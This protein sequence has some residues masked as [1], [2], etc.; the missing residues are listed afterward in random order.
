VSRRPASCRSRASLAA[1]VD[2]VRHVATGDFP[3]AAN[4]LLVLLANLCSVLQSHQN[5]PVIG[6]RCSGLSLCPA[7]RKHP[8]VPNPWRTSSPLRPGLGFPVHTAS[9]VEGDPR[10][11]H[12]E[13]YSVSPRVDLDIEFADVNVKR[14]KND[15]EV[16]VVAAI[17]SAERQGDLRRGGEWRIKGDV[18]RDEGTLPTADIKV[19]AGGF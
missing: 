5:T 15:S 18:G 19:P 9:S 10:N 11:P 16:R 6:Q 12:L 2:R 1:A 17:D 8:I 3:A 13:D 4:S 14:G 7:G